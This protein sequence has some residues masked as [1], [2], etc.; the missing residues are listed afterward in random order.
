[1]N[2]AGFPRIEGETARG[3]LREGAVICGGR[4]MRLAVVG[5]CREA[6]G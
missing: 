3:K 5:M 2:V 6:R 4:L 1:M